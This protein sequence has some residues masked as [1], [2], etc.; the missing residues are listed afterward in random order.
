MRLTLRTMLAYLDDVLDPADAEVLGTRISENEFASELVH[1]IRSSTRKMRLAAPEMDQEGVG[2]ELNSVAEYL[3]NVL[4]ENELADFERVCLESDLH[5]AEVA[6]CH[7]ILTLVLGEPAMVDDEIRQRVYR[8][9][10]NQQ[11]ADQAPQV[12]APSVPGPPPVVV[13]PPPLVT[14]KRTDQEGIPDF[15]QPAGALRVWHVAVAGGLL[16]ALV[17]AFPWMS[18][19]LGWQ[20]DS[21]EQR[22]PQDDSSAVTTSSAGK[23]EGTVPAT[24]FSPLPVGDKSSTT[25]PALVTAATETVRPGAEIDPLPGAKVDPVTA[26]VPSV[27]QLV[28]QDQLVWRWQDDQQWVPVAAKEKLTS[29]DRYMVPPGFHPRLILAEGLQ[30]SVVGHS[31]WHWDLTQSQQPRLVLTGGRFVFRASNARQDPVL[32]SAAGREGWLH[33]SSQFS[34]VALEVWSYLG[35]G[36]DPRKENR[37]T[38]VRIYQSAGSAWTEQAADLTNDKSGAMVVSQGLDTQALEHATLDA[39]PVWAFGPAMNQSFEAT[40]VTELARSIMPDQP[41]LIQLQ[42]CHANHRLHEV[43]ALAAR[44]LA[45]MGYYGAIMDCFQDKSYRASWEKHLLLLQDLIALDVKTA[46]QIQEVFEQQRG[47]QAQQLFRLLWGYDADQL[48]ATSARELVECLSHESTDVRVLAFLNLKR[49]TG[50]TQLFFPEKPISQQATAI[51]GWTRLLDE[52]AITHVHGP[53]PWDRSTG[54]SAP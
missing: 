34:E 6:S 37:Q 17:M 26:T 10:A 42:E 18:A 1:R 36:K 28:S 2:V 40:A 9:E 44:S 27:G 12:E 11:V 5:L 32:V 13:D 41:L 4:P 23:V 29:T 49:I 35:P 22:V 16:L 15:M 47:D 21:G 20:A 43:R 7:Q 38:A 25:A 3:D 19:R 53:T 8:V 54:F 51:R 24:V 33:L 50:K 31:A 39:M 45:V 52:G 46:V 14:D 48:E 30:M